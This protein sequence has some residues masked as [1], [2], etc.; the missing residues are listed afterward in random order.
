[1]LALPLRNLPR[2]RLHLC[3]PP[4]AYMQASISEIVCQAMVESGQRRP[5]YPGKTPQESVLLFLARYLKAKNS[6]ATELHAGKVR[7]QYEG[8]LHDCTVPQLLK[9]L[10]EQEK[11]GTKTWT[12][13]DKQQFKELNRHFDVLF[14]NVDLTGG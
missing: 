11:E 5:L 6:V 4:L 12:A 14:E 3:N 2:Q 9:D 1:M 8:F 10:M 7:K 13:W